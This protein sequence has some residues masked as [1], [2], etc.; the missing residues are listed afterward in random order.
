[1]VGRQL[2]RIRGELSEISVCDADRKSER[3]EVVVFLIEKRNDLGY[4]GFS[5]LAGDD[6]AGAALSVIADDLVHV[7]NVVE[8]CVLGA[9]GGGLGCQLS[10]QPLLNVFDIAVN[11]DH[12]LQRLEV[13]LVHDFGWGLLRKFRLKHV[14]DEVVL[15]GVGAG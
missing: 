11:R 13:T 8:E 1:M 5:F 7:L 12:S 10:N 4:D 2:A 3:N 6:G 15:P 14:V 9:L